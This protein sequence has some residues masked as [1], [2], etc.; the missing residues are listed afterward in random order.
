MRLRGILL[1]G[2]ALVLPL[3]SAL[4]ADLTFAP[5]PFPETDEQKRQILAS[6]SVTIDGAEHK[7][8]YN[9]I[10]RSGDEIGGTVFGKLV[11]A[12]GHP[13][14]NTDGSEHISVD[15]DFSSLLPVG[16]KLFNI[17][18]FESRPGAMYLSELEQDSA[19]GQLTAISTQPIDFSAVGGLWVPCAGSVTPW[20]TH[21]GSEEYPPNA[22]EVL[23]AEALE[24]IDD[25][26]F[27]MARYYGLNPEEMTLEEFRTEFAPYKYGYPTEIAVSEDG[28]YEVT[29]HYAA[30]R[31]A[32]E[33]AFVMP[34]EKTVYI[35]DDGTNVGLFMFVADEAGKLDAGTLYAAK[36]NQT[37]D[38]GAGAADL[39]WVSLGHATSDEVKAAIDEGVTFADLFETADMAEDG[40][41][42]EGFTA[43]NTTD[44][45]ECLKVKEGMETVASRVETR[46]YAA[47][48]GATTEF[49]KEEGIT[50]NADDNVL[51]VAMSE[52]GKGMGDGGD[53]DLGGPND[54]RLADNVCGAVY[55]LS[56]AAD[57]EVGSEFVAQTMTSLVE[58]VPTAYAADSPYANN[59]C[60]IDGIANPD[61]V[62]FMTGYDTLIIGEDSGSG[63]QNDMI[64][65]YNL[66]SGELTR[67]QTTPYGSET[68]SPYVYS[69]INGWGYLMSVVQHPYGE[70]DEDK[71][72]DAADAMAYV[73]YVGPLPPLSN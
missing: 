70:S 1:A 29:K 21:L 25:Y 72:S 62:T 47:M 40:T 43:I 49:R 50:Y 12:K 41:C 55:E 16:D 22:R 9:T 56:L 13:V 58:G 71:L 57:D 73:G 27:P 64:W 7:I 63:H 48:M 14:L 68:T 69:N 34:D 24:E 60:D 46:R 33:L 5:V 53:D 3:T 20:N 44:G 31:V 26:F 10:A 66:S 61:N 28:S 59:E 45:A 23:E 67:I 37:S 42:G 52:V 11:D 2:T 39:A 15:A 18:H 17:T 6:E 54:I 36:W 30:G 32:L 35:S 65:A 51:Y 19:T 38:E 4:A 8:G